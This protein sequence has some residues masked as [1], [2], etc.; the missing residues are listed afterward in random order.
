MQLVR[1]F[2]RSAHAAIKSADKRK[3]LYHVPL[4]TGR[5]GRYWHFPTQTV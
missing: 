1:Q 5:D 3:L 4:R 2:A